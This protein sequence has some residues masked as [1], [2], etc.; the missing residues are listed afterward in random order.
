[1]LTRITLPQVRDSAFLSGDHLAQRN[2]RRMSGNT[3]DRQQHLRVGAHGLDLR[4]VRLSPQPVGVRLGLFRADIPQLL[5]HD[6][7]SI[8]Q[9]DRSRLFLVILERLFG[10]LELR[11]QRLRLLIEKRGGRLRGLLAFVE[12]F[13]NRLLHD[14]VRDLPG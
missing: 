10:L 12:I 2:H 9:R 4:V 5:D 1:M 14:R 3:I 8:F 13:L 11:A 7:L 6:I